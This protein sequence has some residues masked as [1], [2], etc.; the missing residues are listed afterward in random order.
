MAIFSHDV[1]FEYNEIKDDFNLIKK[2]DNCNTKEKVL[3]LVK[4]NEK[5]EFP[6]VYKQSDDKDEFNYIIFD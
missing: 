4:Q 3:E 6:S 1:D 5:S 2:F